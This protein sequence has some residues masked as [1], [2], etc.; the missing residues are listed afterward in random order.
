M[1]ITIRVISSREADAELPKGKIARAEKVDGAW[2]IT[3]YSCMAW[4]S[5]VSALLEELRPIIK[6]VK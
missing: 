1:D 2:V 4:E 3:L 6:E 5:R